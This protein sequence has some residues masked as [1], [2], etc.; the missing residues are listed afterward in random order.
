LSTLYIRL[1]SKAAAD[2]AEHWLSMPC[3]FA[4]ASNG[5][6]IERE[7]VAPLSELAGAVAAAQHVVLLVAASDVSLLRVKTPPLSAAKLR[8][9][10]PNLVEDQL[11]ADPA[12]CVVVAGSLADGLRTAAVVQR[13]WLDIL[14]QTFTSFGARS[15]V[16]LPA[17][18]CLPYQADS[19]TAAI[20]EQGVDIDVALRISEYDGIG[21]PIMPDSPHTAVAEVL[22]A[23][24]AIVPALPIIFYVP[25]ERVVDYQEALGG[26]DPELEQGVSIFADNWSRWIGGVG[27]TPLNLLSGLGASSGPQVNWRQWRWAI[28]LLLLISVVN[29]IGLNIDWWRMKHEA[30]TLR[31]ALIQTYKSTYPKETVILDVVAQM[32]K[33]IDEAERNAGQAAPDDFGQLAANFAEVLAIEGRDSKAR[34]AVKGAG[35]AKEAGKDE[36]TSIIASLEYHDRSLL[37]HLKPDSQISM[38]KMK[39]ALAARHLTLT[40]SSSGVWQI[41]STK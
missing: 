24:R 31:A 19:V 32:H 27:K 33:K 30:S 17:Q 41:R 12:E 21:L 20:T 9:A 40:S 6:A 8:L 28:A 34:K 23:L 14:S 36:S 3:P 2:G 29:A 13:G 5:D 22:G 37:V 11:M 1:P 26:G 18:L 25:Q 38:D 4:L 16:A 39:R 10:L 35:T 7:G 15:L